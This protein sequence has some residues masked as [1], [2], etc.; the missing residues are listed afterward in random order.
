MFNT[1]SLRDLQVVIIDKL[2]N[3]A[4]STDIGHILEEVNKLKRIEEEVK[5]LDRALESGVNV[6]R[7]KIDQ[8]SV[9]YSKA[10]TR[11]ETAEKEYLAAK[12]D[13]EKK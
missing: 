5:K 8:A 11:L 4:K 2:F 9:D 3:T 1:D 12:Q 13:C 6:L 10:K 7:D